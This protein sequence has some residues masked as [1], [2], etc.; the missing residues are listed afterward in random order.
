MLSDELLV[1]ATYREVRI[2]RSNE[3]TCYPSREVFPC[4]RHQGRCRSFRGDAYEA[5]S[6][7]WQES[8]HRLRQ[9][10]DQNSSTR[11]NRRVKAWRW[12]D[13]FHRELYTCQR[14]D[15]ECPSHLSAPAGQFLHPEFSD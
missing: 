9:D 7:A 4:M 12:V 6:F 13:H 1:S 15:D 11:G 5:R 10:P 8:S 3:R 2:G 14:S